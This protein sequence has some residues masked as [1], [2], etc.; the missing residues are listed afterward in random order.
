LQSFLVEYDNAL[1]AIDSPLSAMYAKSES[2][3]T[4]CIEDVLIIKLP[5]PIAGL[6]SVVVG[7]IK[8]FDA[9][10]LFLL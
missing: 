4:F 2:E 5:K 6:I 9:I 10:E 1:S 8:F 7:S 3:Y